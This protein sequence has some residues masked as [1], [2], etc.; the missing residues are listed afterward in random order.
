L[1]FNFRLLRGYHYIHNFI[2]LLS[3]QPA[4]SQPMSCKL[5]LGDLVAL[6]GS[7][8]VQSQAREP[9]EQ[10][11]QLLPN[12]IIGEQLVHPAPPIFFCNLHKNSRKFPSFWGFS[13]DPIVHCVLIYTF[14]EKYI[15]HKVILWIWLY[16][17]FFTNFCFLSRKV[18]QFLLPQPK[19][20][21][22]TYF[23]LVVS[24]SAIEDETWTC[25]VY[26]YIRWWL[27]LFL[28]LHKLWFR[29][30]QIN[31]QLEFCVELH[32]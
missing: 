1:S 3:C 18:V 8:V 24:S 19:N 30:A 23:S 5:Y 28:E 29:T 11:E 17:L 20:R 12:K 15:L 25:W 31:L 16:W 9:G 26:I 21:S 4:S 13:P 2:Y 14:F 6:V 32:L 27:K 10:R 7:W 22:R